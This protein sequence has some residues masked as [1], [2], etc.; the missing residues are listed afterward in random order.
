MAYYTGSAADMSGIRSALVAACT[1]NGWTWNAATNVLSKGSL[2]LLLTN[3]AINMSLTGR[4]SA[5]S[6]NMPNEVQIGRLM[7]KAGTPTLDVT[8]PAQYDIFVFTAPVDEVWLTVRYDVDRYQWCAFGRSVIQLPGTGMFVAAIRGSV[9]INHDV[10]TVVSP[11]H[12]GPAAGGADRSGSHGLTSGAFGWNTSG[13]AFPAQRDVYLHS[14]LDGNGWNLRLNDPSAAL[15]G[16]NAF[17]QLVAAQPSAWN[18]EAALIPMRLYRFRASNKLSLVAD[19]VNVR[20]VRNDNYVPG[21]IIEIGPDR[22]KT[23]PWHRRDGVVRNGTGGGTAF[24]NID[25]SGTF[26]YAVRYDGP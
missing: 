17:S 12:I 24:D 5:S 23:F 15:P 20:H 14:D 2:H 1:D 4:T 11:F 21:Q 18:S 6:G 26:G 25:H 7:A 19:L 9:P 22:W 13:R 10:P 3:D 16:V 8:Y